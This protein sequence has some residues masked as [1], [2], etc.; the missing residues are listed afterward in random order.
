MIT[1]RRFLPAL[2]LGLLLSA[3]DA[4]G[5]EVAS[6]PAAPPAGVE[7]APAVDNDPPRPW[8]GERTAISRWAVAENRARCAPLALADDGGA[9][10]TERPAEFARG[11]A[12]AFDKPGM[13]SAYGFAGVGLLDGDNLPLEEQRRELA[14]QWPYMVALDAALP[15]G[16]VA[17]YGLV[18]AKPYAEGN[19]GGKGEE[20]LAYLRV[21]GEACLYNVWSR[22]GRE[23]LLTL[24]RGL[25]VLR[26]A[27]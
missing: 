4:S 13:R 27:P 16:S 24:L 7:P 23:H 14:A 25:R 17:G 1:C 22:L 15:A 12:V 20:S 6:A 26:P 10:G 9:M 5:G 18:G 3:C 8:I 2:V 19:P 21:A 11:W